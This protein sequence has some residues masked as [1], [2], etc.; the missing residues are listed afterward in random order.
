MEREDRYSD[1]EDLSD[2]EALEISTQFLKFK[3]VQVLKDLIDIIPYNMQDDRGRTLLHYAADSGHFKKVKFLIESGLVDPHLKDS[4]SMNALEISSKKGFTHII[5]YLIEKG[6]SCEIPAS[7]QRLN[8]LID[9]DIEGQ[10]AAAIYADNSMELDIKVIRYVH[11]INGF[12]SLPDFYSWTM[13]N[14]AG[15]QLSPKCLGYL[16]EHGGNWEIESLDD[17]YNCLDN[18]LNS[19]ISIMPPEDEQEWINVSS[20]VDCIL[21]L[22]PKV[23][24]LQP[25]LFRISKLLKQASFLGQGSSLACTSFEIDIDKKVDHMRMVLSNLIHNSSLL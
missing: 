20:G 24:N 10:I 19:L 8:E 25:Y 22:V 14:L 9:P 16:L 21:N 18:V 12:F 15:S 5:D 4:E 11:N 7:S 3:S 13:V 23:D 6:L 17:G 1:G 2:N